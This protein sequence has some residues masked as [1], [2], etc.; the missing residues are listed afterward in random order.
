MFDNLTTRLGGVFDRLRRR[1]ALGEA[2]VAEA[3]REIRVALLEADV[4]L[5]VV[6]DFVNGIKERAVGQEVIRSVTPGQQVVKIV[7]DRLVELLG[8]EGEAGL[9]LGPVPSVVLMCGL[10]GSGKTTTAGKLAAR[11]M[12]RE[13]KK[14]LLASLDVYRPAAQRQLEVLAQQTGAGS[15]PIV[16]G[17]M[18]VDITRRALETARREGYDV[19]VLDTAGRLQIDD[20]LMDELAM[21]KLEADPQE[22]L[23]VAD[24][25]TGQAAVDIG[26]AFNEQIGVDGIVLT[27]MDGDARG[28]AA[29]SMRAITG[30]PI[31]FVGTGEK[32]E[33]LEPFHP[34]R[35]ASR[36]LDMGDVVSL[37]ENA[38][39][40]I[41]REEAE[42]LAR[43]VQKGK[44]DLE[45]YRSQLQQIKKMGGMQG[46]IGMLPGVKKIKQQLESSKVD[47]RIFLRQTAIIDSMTRKERRD[48][49]VLNASRKRRVA[50]GSGTTVQ[51]V[52]QLLKQHRQMQDMMKQMK[53]MGGMQNLLGKL[54]KGMMPPGMMP[55]F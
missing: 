10:Q 8:G 26:K 22:T 35:V 21:V 12:K 25:L 38:V 55:K 37:V 3:L 4:A 41:D 40:N 11:L 33:Q 15:L 27:R 31:K 14:V 43:K 52:N 32:L 28:G 29:L 42:K 1:G 53:K 5:P 51:D 2:D 45:D 6:K 19:L 13:R 23:L 20:E 9:N 30:K 47:E 18:P 49:E 7:H 39:E 24:G 50:K 17:Q 36:I 46:V 48:P 34:D 16:A 54:P 44:F